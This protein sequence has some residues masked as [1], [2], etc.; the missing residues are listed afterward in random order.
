LLLDE[1]LDNIS[2]QAKNERISRWGHDLRIG[3]GRGVSK[4]GGGFEGENKENKAN[5]C[6]RP[7]HVLTC[8]IFVASDESILVTEN[9]NQ[10]ACASSGRGHQRCP[11]RSGR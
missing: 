7:W 6:A 4:C 5:E 10:H 1:W 11:L 3:I 8:V 9:F 2:W